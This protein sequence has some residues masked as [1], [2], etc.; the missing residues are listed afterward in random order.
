[1]A[2]VGGSNSIAPDFDDL[3]ADLLPRG[4]DATSFELNLN[5]KDTTNPHSPF[6]DTLYDPVEQLSR[7]QLKLHQCLTSIKAVGKLKKQKL[8][9]MSGQVGEIDTS[10]LQGLFRTTERFINALIG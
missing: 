5:S 9:N 2:G 6:D 10:W 8:H 3:P 7:F 1:M 4:I